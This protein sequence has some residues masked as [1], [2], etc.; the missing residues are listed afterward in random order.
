[1]I[2]KL[3]FLKSLFFISIIFLSFNCSEEKLN[4]DSLNNDWDKLDLKGEV[5]SFRQIH[6]EAKESFGEVVKKIITQ[7]QINLTEKKYL[8]KMVKL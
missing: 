5:K 3:Q 7:F 4:N 8:M 6:F 2:I 1:M